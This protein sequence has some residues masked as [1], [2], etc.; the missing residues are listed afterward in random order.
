MTQEKDQI[1]IHFKEKMVTLHFEPLDAD[2][3][4]DDLLRIHYENLMGEILTISPLMNRVGW[5][6]AEAQ[7]AVKS[8]NLELQIYEAEAKE[9]FR[10]NSKVVGKDYKGNDKFKWATKDEVD[11]SVFG[12]QTYLKKRRRVIRIEKEYEYIDSLYWAVKSKEGKLNRI[13]DHL[14]PEEFEKDLVAGKINGFMIKAH[15]KLIK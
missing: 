9:L 12:D 7:G 5:L 8:A 4:V 15:E 11:N 10:K 14:K 13:A 6:K 3:D 2:I 1:V